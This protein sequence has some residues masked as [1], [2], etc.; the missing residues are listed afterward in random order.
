MQSDAYDVS[1]CAPFLVLLRVQSVAFI[2][3]DK[4][5]P[6]IVRPRPTLALALCVRSFSFL[7]FL[8]VAG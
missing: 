3:H 6:K 5:D 7:F 8:F 4:C 2:A 1:C